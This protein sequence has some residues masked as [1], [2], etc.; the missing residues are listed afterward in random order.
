MWPYSVEVRSLWRL[1]LQHLCGYPCVANPKPYINVAAWFQ[2]CIFLAKRF[3][4]FLKWYNFRFF[5]LQ[6]YVIIITYFSWS[7]FLSSDQNSML[8]ETVF[9][10]SKRTNYGKTIGMVNFSQ[11]HVVHLRAN[12]SG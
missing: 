7:F 4:T 12:R 3:P 11:Q 9:A 10:T 2:R 8:I 6:N 5:S 1:A